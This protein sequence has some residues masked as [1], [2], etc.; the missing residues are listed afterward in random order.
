M[1]IENNIIVTPIKK[2]LHYELL[3]ESDLDLDAF[4]KLQADLKET[5]ELNAPAILTLSRS[6]GIAKDGDAWVISLTPEQTKAI[7]A[8]EL[9]MDL[10]AYND[11]DFVSNQWE[12]K[13]G[14]PADL[15]DFN[16]DFTNGL[17][18]LLEQERL[19]YSNDLQNW[20]ASTIPGDFLFSPWRGIV[21]GNNTYVIYNR[22]GEFN[23]AYSAD[24]VNWTIVQDLQFQ[25]L[26]EMHFSEEK[27][28]FI[29]TS[30]LPTGGGG[31]DILFTSPDGQTWT[32]RSTGAPSTE[33][34][35]HPKTGN[36][37]I[38]SVGR[39]GS[40]KSTDG[41]SWTYTLYSGFSIGGSLSFGNGLFVSRFGN[42]V[43]IT[44]DGIT[45]ELVPTPQVGAWEFDFGKG[46][47]VGTKAS[48][49]IRI[50]V[51]RNGQNWVQHLRPKSITYLEPYFGNGLF[52]SI[53]KTGPE[54]M[55][56]PPFEN[57]D[58]VQVF[59]AKM[60]IFETITDL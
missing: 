30:G 15:G 2:G 46:F 59:S 38:L 47:F 17:Y 9:Y 4:D 26:A 48:G 6:N 29:V 3:F 12:E 28:I 58:P 34:F 51:S 35:R 11:A 33:Y 27:G 25:L 52:F 57:I 14:L 39:F 37:F 20:Q 60:P 45:Y 10:K 40:I 5:P 54:T 56:S 1:K 13:P 21:F 7:Q 41:L 50:M 36:G 42:D 19:F 22:L 18:F 32:Q 55:I 24:L 16:Y 43:R 8:D 49:S 31:G 44:T 53:S 23:L